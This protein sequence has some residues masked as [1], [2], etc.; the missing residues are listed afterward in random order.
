LWRAESAIDHRDYS[1]RVRLRKRVTEGVS[2]A[3]LE[4]RHRTAPSVERAER[5]RKT[6]W[7]GALRIASRAGSGRV[8]RTRTVSTGVPIVNLAAG[9]RQTTLERPC[10]TLIFPVDVET[11]LIPATASKIVLLQPQRIGRVQRCAVDVGVAVEGLG[12]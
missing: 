10:R 8:V 11:G 12:I 5:D 3:L 6:A 7:C 1:L 2:H 9:R 4:K